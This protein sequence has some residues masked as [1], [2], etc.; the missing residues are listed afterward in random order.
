MCK[1]EYNPSVYHNNEM[2]IIHVGTLQW[3]AIIG[4]SALAQWVR[5]SD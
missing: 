2:V 5:A 1:T 3:L 4:E